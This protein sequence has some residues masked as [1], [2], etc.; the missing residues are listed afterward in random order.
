VAGDGSSNEEETQV[1]SM[2]RWAAAALLAAVIAL[3]G[4]AAAADTPPDLTAPATTCP[5]P[6]ATVTRGANRPGDLSDQEIATLSSLERVDGYP[7]YVMRYSGS[8]E[9]AVS[10]PGDGESLADGTPFEL[11]PSA[12]AWACALFAALGDPEGLLYGRGFDWEYSPAM[13]L[14]TDPPD[15]YAS[16]SM[17]DIAYLVDSVDV[18]ALTELSIDQRR[19]LLQA[20]FWPFDGMNE[21]GLVVGM[22]AVYE[23]QVPY[24]P[25]KET[26]GSLTIIRQLLDHARDVDE[27][28]AL[29]EQVNIDM[30]GGPPLHYVIA[31]RSGR[32]V[33]VEFYREMVVIPNDA[34]WHAATNHLRVTADPAGPSGCPRYDTIRQRLTETAGRLTV[35]D[36]MDVLADV[37]AGHTQ[38]S[39]V[40]GMTTGEVLVAMGRQYDGVH[41]F[42]LT[43]ASE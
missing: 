43:L 6:A 12:P 34:P 37:S 23:S 38:W 28:V 29:M 17:V 4:C 15:G 27:A 33:L 16:V 14:F 2:R 11:R 5:T 39:I 32:A 10:L 30:E 21:H 20:P 8:Y 13:L 24:D 42:H 25:Q 36:A 22:A 3:A 19:P 26:T 40:Y 31:D 41:A 1:Q 9:A 35:R 18:A 7:L